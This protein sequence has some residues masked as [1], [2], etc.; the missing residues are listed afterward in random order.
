MVGY[1]LFPFVS[2]SLD[3]KLSM[4]HRK[5]IHVDMDAFFVSV[6]ELDDPSLKG[7]PV[8]VGHDGPRGVVSTA[9]YVARQYGVH[10][11]QPIAVAHR[12]C[13]DLLVVEP[14]FSRYKEVS[15][16][17]HDIFH[18]YTDLIEP[19]SLDEAYLDVTDNKFGIDMAVD[20]A[21]E[22]K[23]RIRQ[24]TGLTASAG[25]SYCKFLAKVASDYRKPDGLCTVHPE[26]AL[27]FID[28]LK[29]E[30]FWGV[31]EKTAQHMHKMGVFTGKQL[32]GL[33]LQQ[34]T[35][36]F[37][38]MG[39]VF[40]DFARGIDDRPVVTEWVRKSVGCERTYI[41]DITRQEDMLGELSIL[42]DELESR[43]ARNNF[44]G[45]TLVLKVKFSDFRQ[46]THSLT[47]NVVIE[48]KEKIMALVKELLNEVDFQQ[49]PVRLLGITVTN[50]V[51]EEGR[52]GPIQLYIEW[53][54]V[55]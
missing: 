37:G 11:A 33:T 10:S 39:K 48:H 4:K 2:P 9:N 35:T 20:I 29:V 13:P 1:S 41:K 38:K 47:E 21:R 5:I 32:R 7:K 44:K 43:L 27:K 52:R 40:Y 49:R 23:K 22:I 31:G 24:V 8:V 19:L 42:A 26:R 15:R 54:P 14:H 36:Q 50:P 25:V 51:E 28:N 17:V 53:P 12:L 30:Q 34:L 18:E 16:Q 45:R 6:E 3:K 55:F 46:T